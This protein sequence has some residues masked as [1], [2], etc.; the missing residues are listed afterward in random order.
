MLDLLGDGSERREWA[1]PDRSLLPE[2]RPL[3]GPLGVGP[4]GRPLLDLDEPPKADV[5]D[6]DV[7]GAARGVDERGLDAVAERGAGGGRGGGGQEA[8]EDEGERRGADGDGARGV[9]AALG[10]V[11]APVEGV[12]VGDV[13]ERRAR[14]RVREL[15]PRRRRHAV[16]RV[17]VDVLLRVHHH[18]RWLVGCFWLQISFFLAARVCAVRCGEGWGGRNGETE[19]RR[20]L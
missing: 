9:E 2:L 19:E 10:G 7:H 18:G 16:P 1:A 11:E 3:V 17:P 13:G 15:A 12:D 4:V 6:N 14:G 20:I 5:A 8:A